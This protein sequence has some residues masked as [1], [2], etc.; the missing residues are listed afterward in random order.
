MISS[1]FF[2]FIDIFPVKTYNNI[3][4]GKP[5][6]EIPCQ[7][8]DTFI[9]RRVSASRQKRHSRKDYT[10]FIFYIIS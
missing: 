7:I 1:E 9:F 10:I 6:Q 2:I 8:V 5:S 4:D 3:R